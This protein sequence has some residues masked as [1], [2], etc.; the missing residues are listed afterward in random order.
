MEVRGAVGLFV[1]G[2]DV[3]SGGECWRS[4]RTLDYRMRDESSARDKYGEPSARI[5]K[6][7]PGF[8]K[9]QRG[10]GTGDTKRR[11]LLQRRSRV[12]RPSAAGSASGGTS[13]GRWSA[14]PEA[15]QQG[16]SPLTARR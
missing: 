2:A 3:R 9:S 5:K 1:S 12:L 7:P 13:L 15:P 14:R 16:M 4:A 10:R 8:K 11:R 6:A